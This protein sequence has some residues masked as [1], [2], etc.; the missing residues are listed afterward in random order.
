VQQAWSGSGK[1]IGHH[2]TWEYNPAIKALADLTMIEI[3]SA[4]IAKMGTS[5]ETETRSVQAMH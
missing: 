1:L 3:R 2:Q 5:L 4:R